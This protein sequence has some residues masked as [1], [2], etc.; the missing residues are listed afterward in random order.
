MAICIRSHGTTGD[1]AERKAPAHGAGAIA[2]FLV[3]IACVPAIASAHRFGGPD[4]P[5]ERK[6][7]TS[8]IHITLYQPQFDP[9]A[10]YC[11]LVPRAG[12]TVLIIDM[13]GDQLRKMPMGVE[14][15]AVGPS[16]PARTILSMPPQVYRRGVADAQIRL[17]GDSPYLVRIHLEGAGA[18]GS[19]VL[20]FPIR[21][22]SWYRAFI[23]PSLIVL[24]VLALM[25]LTVV[26]Y[27]MSSSASVSAGPPVRLQLRLIASAT[28]VCC[29][30]T[31]CSRSV[32]RQ[33]PV[34]PDVQVIDDHG[35]QMSL[36]ALRGKVVLLEFIHIGCPVVCDSLINK[37]GQIA[38]TLG[39]NLGSRVVLLS[40]T[41]DPQNDS[42]PK[43]LELARSRAADFDGWLFVTGKPGDVDRIIKAFGL[44][45]E[46][47]PDG[48][49][50]HITQVFLLG[51]DLRARQQ[52]AGMAMD[53]HSVR[54]AIN[55]TLKSGGPS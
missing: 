41:N 28:L 46:R 27:R 36:G 38:D 53:L 42:P 10:E 24:G 26:R 7:G 54:I 50:N 3:A 16:Q 20:L 32:P 17:T 47:L 6:I 21:V 11:E 33:N 45:N 35:R 29:L 8:L 55:E 15:L 22:G 34:L 25:A 18:A 48:S 9:D 2:V 49:P 1:A 5:C 19:Q 12:N 44:H 51:P 37:F 30:L 31:G 13:L 23:A 40:V 39:P 14:V 4:D 52:Y 43:L